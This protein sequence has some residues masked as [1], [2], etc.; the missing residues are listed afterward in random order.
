MAFNMMCRNVPGSFGSDTG[1]LEWTV[2]ADADPVPSLTGG[3]LEG[4]YE[5]NKL[6]VH[7]NDS[8]HALDGES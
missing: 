3:V 7:A 1:N 6:I 4:T 2:D 8:L 5:L